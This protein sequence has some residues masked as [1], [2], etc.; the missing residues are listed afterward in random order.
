MGQIITGIRSIL[1]YPWVYD[2]LQ[3]LMGAKKIR[4]ELVS[5]FIRPQSH[6]HLLDVGCGTG[7]ML[8]YLPESIH[9]WGYDINPIYIDSAKKQFAGRGQFNYG[10]LTRETLI[11]LP[12]FDVVLAVGVLHHLE[13]DEA[14]TFFSLAHEALKEDGRTITLDP[15]FVSGQNSIAHYL[16]RHD[17]GKNVR[18]SNSYLALAA[19]NFRNISGFLRHRTWIPYTHW[20]MECRK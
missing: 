5:E 15:C 4:R 7:I 16:I 2:A 14:K 18:D 6:C 19:P 11:T 12:K 1:S 10:L 20:I 9:Y 8:S 17:R 13:D 3:N